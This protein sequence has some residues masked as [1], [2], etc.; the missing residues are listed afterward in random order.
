MSGRT[1]QWL[2]DSWNQQQKAD[3]KQSARTAV[4][5]LP[6]CGSAVEVEGKGEQWITCPNRLCGK[7]H[8]LAWG[9]K[10]QLR[11]EELLL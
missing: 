3:E 7:R 10:P 11:S 8:M 2:I 5:K 4:V 9:M 1:P 6:C